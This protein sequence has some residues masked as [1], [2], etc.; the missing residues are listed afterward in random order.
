MLC[1]PYE[2]SACGCGGLTG[3]QMCAADGMSYGSCQCP[4]GTGGSGGSGGSSGQGGSSGVGGSSTGGSGGAVNCDVDGDGHKAIAC[5]GDDCN[6][7]VAS[8]N[9]SKLEVCGNNVD[10]N[11]NGKT[12]EGCFDADGDGHVAL[13]NGGDDCNDN[14]VTIYKGHAEVCGNGKDNDCDGVVD[15]GCNVANDEVT[16]KCYYASPVDGTHAYYALGFDDGIGTLNPVKWG[17]GGQPYVSTNVIWGSF[18][19]QIK[20]GNGFV[21]N[22]AADPITTDWHQNGFWKSAATTAAPLGLAFNTYCTVTDGG[23]TKPTARPIAV[24]NGNGYANIRVVAT[25]STLI[26]ANDQDGDGFTVGQ[27]DCADTDPGTYPAAIEIQNDGVDRNCDGKDNSPKVVYTMCGVTSGYAPVVRNAT[28]W[29]NDFVMHWNGSC[30]ESDPVWASS[31]AKEF[32]VE[33][34]NPVQYDNSYWGGAC[35]ELT[36]GVTMKWDTNVV[37]SVTMSKAS[38]VDACHRYASF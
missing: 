15:N 13:A 20:K 34:G 10:E 17:E 37:I 36:S 24:P 21:Y 16:L 4:C 27:G 29:G 22:V 18:S 25:W 3:S 9:P 6:D 38:G 23:V 14:D 32:W 8:I 2:P 12:N 7:N 26:S 19:V 35:H 5:G 31:A 11:C 33:W 30:F 28:F 1:T